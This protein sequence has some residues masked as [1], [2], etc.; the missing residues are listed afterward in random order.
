MTTKSKQTCGKS[1]TPNK[2]LLSHCRKKQEHTYL[3]EKE[4]EG[5]NSVEIDTKK[6]HSYPLANKNICVI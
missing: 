6:T 1:F 2:D 4:E 3:S 5:W